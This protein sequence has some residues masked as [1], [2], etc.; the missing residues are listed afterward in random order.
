M[1]TPILFKTRDRQYLE[2]VIFPCINTELKP[3]NILS[4]GVDWYTALYFDYFK[5]SLFVSIDREGEKAKFATN[6]PHM[7]CDIQEISN[8]FGKVFDLIIFNGVYGHGCNRREDLHNALN[9]MHSCLSECGVILVGYNN[10]AQLNPLS[11]N[12]GYDFGPLEITIG[13]GGAPGAYEVEGSNKHTYIY[14]KAK[15]N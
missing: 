15:S 14:L 9:N 8:H 10:T 2:R 12:D 3:K 4:V 5:D 13:P 7:T 11:I 1:S 6:N